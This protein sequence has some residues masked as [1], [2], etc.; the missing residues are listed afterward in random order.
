MVFGAGGIGESVVTIRQL[1]LTTS[2]FLWSANRRTILLRYQID[3]SA[4]LLREGSNATGTPFQVARGAWKMFLF[5]W[6]N[7]TSIFF[8]FKKGPFI[9]S[10]INYEVN[11]QYISWSN[12]RKQERKKEPL[13]GWREQVSCYITT[14]QFH[15]TSSLTI[16]FMELFFPYTHIL[17]LVHKI[18][19]WS[20]VLSQQ[21]FQ[22]TEY[23]NF[24]HF[25]SLFCIIS[26]C[27]QVKFVFYQHNTYRN[28][29]V[30]PVF[31]LDGG[32]CLSTN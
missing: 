7:L 21:K 16:A 1:V 11:N 6:K 23:H 29:D 10:N 5:W 20:L 25:M 4:H 13:L 12:I 19:F 14:Q 18:H 2:T 31:S 15:T 22:W 17:F 32:S 3:C 27:W 30:Y 8:F 24:G 28:W 9:F 26:P